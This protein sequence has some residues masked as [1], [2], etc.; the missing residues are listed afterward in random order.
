MEVLLVKEGDAKDWHS[1]IQISKDL[2]IPGYEYVL[3]VKETL[4]MPTPADASSIKYTLV[5][6]VS[7]T[8]KVSDNMLKGIVPEY[9]WNAKV[10]EI[11][12]EDVGKGGAEG[13][14]PVEVIKVLVTSQNFKR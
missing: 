4:E 8:E 6:E 10:L 9:V 12:A 7:K 13:K 5:K 11:K 14:F 3:D 1:S 2:T